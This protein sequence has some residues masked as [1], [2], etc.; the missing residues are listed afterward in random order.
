MNKQNLQVIIKLSNP[1]IRI[2]P[3]QLIIDSLSDWDDEDRRFGRRPTFIRH[4]STSKT[5]RKTCSYSR[6]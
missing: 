1:S 5:L 3:P 4:R 6:R 2:S